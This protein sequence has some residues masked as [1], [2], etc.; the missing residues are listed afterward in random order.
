MHEKMNI[1]CFFL[2]SPSVHLVK[3]NIDFIHFLIK[4]LKRIYGKSASSV[5]S[6]NVM[7]FKLAII[8]GLCKIS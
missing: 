7:N 8:T 2:L 6:F 4:I 1:V 5:D 3:V